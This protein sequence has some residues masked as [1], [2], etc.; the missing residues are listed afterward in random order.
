MAE[1]KVTLAVGKDELDFNV[2]TEDFNRYL[3]ELTADNKVIPGKRFLRRCLVDKAQTELLE[4]LMD[5]G[6]TFNMTGELMQEFQGDIEIE[7]K[8]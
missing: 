8:K 1:K 6:L 7:V 4:S 3:N 2:N 5:R